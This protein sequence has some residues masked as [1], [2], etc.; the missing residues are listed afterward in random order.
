MEHCS[1]LV[2][3]SCLRSGPPAPECCPVARPLNMNHPCFGKPVNPGAL[4]TS[5]TSLTILISGYSALAIVQIESVLR[6]FGVLHSI[7]A[8]SRAWRTAR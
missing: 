7:T 2:F 1:A 5:S 6:G 3:R 4:P 8:R